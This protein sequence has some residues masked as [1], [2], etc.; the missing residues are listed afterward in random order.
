MNLD[1]A[2]LSH[3]S[4]KVR[5][6][7]PPPARIVFVKMANGTIDISIKNSSVR[8]A[9]DELDMIG[10]MYE[11]LRKSDKIVPTSTTMILKQFYELHENYEK[12]LAVKDA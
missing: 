4:T 6:V 10:V 11:D 9:Q 8:I 12:E 5:E 7:K 1:Q 3:T 2:A